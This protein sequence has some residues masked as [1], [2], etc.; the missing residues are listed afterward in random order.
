MFRQAHIILSGYLADEMQIPEISRHKLSLYIGAVMPDSTP[1][2]RMKQHEF[3]VTWEDTKER[4]RMIETMSVTDARSER[5]LCRQL[6]ITQH[7]LA[8]FFT[9]PHNHSYGLNLM[10]HGI[11]EGWEALRLRQYLYTPEADER[12]RSHKKIAERLRDTD[13]LFSYIDWKHDRYMQADSHT[14]GGDCRWILD[15]CTCAT[16][17]L[18]SELF[19]DS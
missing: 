11:Y 18:A 7:Y 1:K 9:C 4:I 15:V 13:E 16:V 3:L 19:K 17:W 8:D 10:E 12:F 5:A 2:L 14:P 6:G